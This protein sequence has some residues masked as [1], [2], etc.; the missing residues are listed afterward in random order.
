MAEHPTCTAAACR[1]VV[2]RRSQM[3]EA[4]FRRYL[5]AQVQQRQGAVAC[6]R[7]DQAQRAAEDRAHAAVWAVVQLHLGSVVAEDTVRL[8]VP[9]GPGRRV[10]LAQRRVTA[11]RQHLQTVVAE[12]MAGDEAAAPVKAAAKAS[13]SGSPMQQHLCGLCGGGCC[14]HGGD[15]AYLTADTV[16]R[17]MRHHPQWSPADVVQAYLDRVAPRTERLSCINHTAGG[18]ALPREMRSDTCNDFACAALTTLQRLP[19]EAADR[20]SVIAI[21]RRLGPW[22]RVPHAPDNAITAIALITNEGT[23]RLPLKLAAAA[24]GECTEGEA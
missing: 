9:S 14:T 23:R 5:R 18:C 8:A 2:S 4:G 7:R 1:L 11:Y 21:R 13:A 12:A 20:Y 15:H 24:A 22:T 17:V 3:D 10:P 16:R 6:I 19:A